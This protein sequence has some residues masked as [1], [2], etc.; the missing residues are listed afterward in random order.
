MAGPYSSG[1]EGFMRGYG[2][3][4][5]IVDTERRRAREDVTDRLNKAAADDAMRNRQY[6]LDNEKAGQEA[7]AKIG[8][9][10]TDAQPATREQAML[11]VAEARADHALKAG[12]LEDFQQHFQASAQ[13]RAQM[14]QQ[15]YADADQKFAATG[16]YSA[17]LKPLSLWKNGV[18]TTAIKPVDNVKQDDQ[19]N[20]LPLPAAG[21]REFKVTNMVDG[22]EYSRVVPE[23]DVKQFVNFARNPQAAVAAELESAKKI[24]ESKLKM[25]EETHKTNEK[26]RENM[27]N[28]EHAIKIVPENASV[29]DAR[30]GAIVAGGPGAGNGKPGDK[31]QLPFDKDI[32]DYLAMREGYGTKD[33]V[34][35][36]A[37]ITQKGGDAASKMQAMRR[38]GVTLGSPQLL[39]VLEKG[40]VGKGSV[41]LPNG[42]TYNGPVINYQGRNYPISQ[43]DIA[44]GAPQAARAPS[45]AQIIATNPYAAE[46]AAMRA[47]A[48]QRENDR[49]AVLR[50]EQA[51]VAARLQ[52][53][54]QDPSLVAQA[55]GL[56]REIAAASAQ[57]PVPVAPPAAPV[58]PPMASGGQAMEAAVK[59]ISAADATGVQVAV[60]FKQL[61]GKKAALAAI[62]ERGRRA[63]PAKY[64]ALQRDVARLEALLRG[65]AAPHNPMVAMGRPSQPSNSSIIAAGR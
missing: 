44:P 1:T 54:P 62:G 31:D 12:K 36:Q 14:R 43:T 15:A 20:N 13:M 49:L 32:V 55:Q 10:A 4:D 33:L 27:A 24:L 25:G 9:G 6:Q 2:F 34:S 37:T 53:A 3:A 65:L 28:P 22:K 64:E 47:G 30:R 57:Q 17:Y 11:T 63:D 56:D 7:F 42:Q 61:E 59:P 29:Y 51:A 40:Q 46:S 38:A 18:D 21:K 8:V 39:E 60:A 58:A 50:Q 35:G 16:D 23:D 52:Q 48:P 19:G 5:A 45:N 41:A 26:I